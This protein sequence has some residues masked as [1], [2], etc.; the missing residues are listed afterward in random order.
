MDHYK[1][2]IIG[3]GPAGLAAAYELAKQNIPAVCLERDAAV[4]GISKT[5]VRDGFRFDVGGHRFFTKIDRVNALWHEVLKNEFIRRPRLSRIYYN[6]RFFR[7]PIRPANVFWNLGPLT[8]AAVLAGFIAARIHPYTREDN[9]QQWV[10]NRFGKKLFDIFFKTYTEKVWGIDCTQIRAEWA[11][12]RIKGLSL[13]SAVKTAL[14]GDKNKNIKTLIEEFDYPRLGPGQMY[15]TMAQKAR[16]MNA[17]VITNRSVRTL[18]HHS[19]KVTSIDTAADSGET[20]NFHADHFLSSMPVDQLVLSLQP[21]PPPEVA[22]AAK[23]LNYRSLLTVNLML[24]GKENFADT[25]IYIHSPEVKMGRL[26]CFKNW[27]PWMVPN[28]NCHSLGLEYFCTEGDDLW[29]TP[30]PQLIELGKNEILKLNLA[31]P[32]AVFD[33]FVVR[34]PKTYPVYAMDYQQRLEVIKQYL[35]GFENLQC[36]GRAGLFKYNNMDHSIYSALL[37]VDNIT[38]DAHNDLW[39]VNVD[40]Q[41]YEQTET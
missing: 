10:T 3:A 28:D 8:S 37:A 22:A 5:I 15:E 26:Q 21:P 18:H 9:L 11:A 4:G 25:W 31:D 32:S 1:A 41:Y 30:D 35:A 34:T 13:A 14:L 6:N 16:Q 36:I 33:A 12:Q 39:A 7:Y 29:Q 24:H 27:S 17:A 23:S 38:R 40:E 20:E 2:A 19:G